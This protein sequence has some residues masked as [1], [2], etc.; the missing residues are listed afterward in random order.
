MSVVSTRTMAPRLPTW[1]PL[2]AYVVA[3]S[4]VAAVVARATPPGLLPPP[5]RPYTNDG[6]RRVRAGGLDYPRRAIGADDAVLTLARAPQ[7]VA[8]YS[9]TLDELAYAV[10]PPSRIVGVSESA[11]QRRISN[12]YE[13]AERFRPA[14]LA[15]N[16]GTDPERVLRAAPD[17]LLA[18]T[19]PRADVTHLMR[20]A[21]VPTYRMFATFATLAQIEQHIRLVGYLSGDDE[22]ARRE[23]ARFHDAVTRAAA[24]HRPGTRPRVLGLGARYSYGPDTLFHDICRVLGAENVAAPHLIGYQ[25]VNAEHIVRW[26]PEWIVAGAEPGQTDAV[27]HRLLSDPAVA[28]TDAAARGQI[29]VLEHH[30]FLPLSPFVTRLVE[31]MA[32]AFYG[33]EARS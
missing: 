32:D 13:T 11:Y 24:R 26:N 6:D 3:L 21:G 8:S 7:R 30:V 29:L 28:A 18:P 9:W 10:V 12:V 25:S 16:G 31:A 2:A 5:Q 17:L 23:A 33:A 19:Q 4:A 1:A 20:A 14:V 15:T 27:R 22:P